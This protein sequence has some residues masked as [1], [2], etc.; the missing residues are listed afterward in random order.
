MGGVNVAA[1]ACSE[2]FSCLVAV[3]STMLLTV[4]DAALAARGSSDVGDRECDT[5][6]TVTVACSLTVA[7]SVVVWVVSGNTDWAW[8]AVTP[9]TKTPNVSTIL[10]VM[11][12]TIFTPDELLVTI[13]LGWYSRLF[14]G[15][16]AVSVQGRTTGNI[17]KRRR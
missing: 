3:A 15:S 11:V 1:L 8:A 2:T 5:R 13:R 10:R 16:H 4:T 14:M 6:G 7:V 17:N 12:F 9:T